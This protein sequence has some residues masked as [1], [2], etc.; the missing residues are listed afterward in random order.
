MQK[1]VLE[2]IAE[3][4][5]EAVVE[6]VGIS[7]LRTMNASNLG[8]VSKIF[9]IHDNGKPLAILMNYDQYLTFQGKLQEAL[10]TLDQVERDLYRQLASLPESS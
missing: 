6:H 5:K 2:I 4:A 10:D 3:V 9:V 7:K 1:E 8:Q